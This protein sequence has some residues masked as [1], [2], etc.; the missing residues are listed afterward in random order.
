MLQARQGKLELEL[1]ELALGAGSWYGTATAKAWNNDVPSIPQ[2]Q[3][4]NWKSPLTL[5]TPT[6]APHSNQLRGV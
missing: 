4:Q 6:P 5:A 1:M 2:K 3:K